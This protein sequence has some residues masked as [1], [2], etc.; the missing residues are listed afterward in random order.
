MFGQFTLL[1]INSNPVRMLVD[2][3]VACNSCLR[4]ISEVKTGLRFHNSEH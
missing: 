4:F 1:Y 3:A 2:R